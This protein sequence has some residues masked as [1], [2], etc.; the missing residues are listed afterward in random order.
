MGAFDVNHDGKISKA[1]WIVSR[2]A[3]LSLFILSQQY[4][5]APLPQ[6][7][8]SACSMTYEPAWGMPAPITTCSTEVTE[9]I[10]PAV[11][12]RSVKKTV[13]KKKKVFSGLSD[14][15]MIVAF[16]GF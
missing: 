9:V 16:I 11:L 4:T 14:I 2:A 15:G 8:P 5:S 6:R 13:K 10:R 3:F 7:F 1:E 12:T